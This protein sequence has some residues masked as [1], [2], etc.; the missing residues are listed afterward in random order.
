MTNLAVIATCNQ[1]PDVRP[2]ISAAPRTRSWAARQERSCGPVPQ[3]W[4]RHHLHQ[5]QSWWEGVERDNPAGCSPQHR[6]ARSAHR[7]I[8]R[9]VAAGWLY[10]KIRQQINCTLAKCSEFQIFCSFSV[11]CNT[12]IS[13][14]AAK[15]TTPRFSHPRLLEPGT[16]HLSIPGYGAGAPRSPPGTWYGASA[17]RGAFAL[18][19]QEAFRGIN[20]HMR[21]LKVSESHFSVI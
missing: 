13:L 3:G 7:K 2:G 18:P 11:F 15:A 20:M 21:S 6:G 4:V 12:L 10:P 14:D 19:P 1:V 17:P 5:R 16:L 9:K 8:T